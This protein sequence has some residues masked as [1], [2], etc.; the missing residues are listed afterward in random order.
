MN[1]SLVS[2]KNVKYHANTTKIMLRNQSARKF[3][4]RKMHLLEGRYCA[5]AILSI[6]FDSGGSAVEII[7]VSI[8]T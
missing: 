6:T 7:V 5:G 1:L 3:V 8:V 4:K 2:A